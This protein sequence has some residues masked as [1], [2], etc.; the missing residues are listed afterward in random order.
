MQEELST[1]P[2][3]R[4][5]RFE[6]DLK[7]LFRKVVKNIDTTRS[8]LQDYTQFDHQGTVVESLNHAVHWKNV[9]DHI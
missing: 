8:L 6:D 1:N 7:T 5:I 4:I 3:S 9:I 2:N